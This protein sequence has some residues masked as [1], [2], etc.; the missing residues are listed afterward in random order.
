MQEQAKV[1]PTPPSFSRRMAAN[2]AAQ[3][4]AHKGHTRNVS[5]TLDESSDDDGPKLYRIPQRQPDS[6]TSAVTSTATPHSAPAS[7]ARRSAPLPLNL[8][9][10][11]PRAFSSSIS[12][13]IRGPLTAPASRLSTSASARGLSITPTLAKG[14]R[15]AGGS[16]WSAN[17]T[18]TSGW[19]SPA[20]NSARSVGS[21]ARQ[22]GLTVAVLMDSKE[23]LLGDVPLTPGLSTGNPLK[24]GG[25][26]GSAPFNGAAIPEEKEGALSPGQT[27]AKHDGELIT[28]RRA[29]LTA[30]VILCRYYHTPGLTCTSRPCR[31]V[32][33]LETIK[34]PKPVDSYEMMS[35]N[36]ADPTVGTFAQA[37]MS[38]QA[39]ILKVD[40]LVSNGAAPGETVVLSNGDGHEVVGT[41]YLMS[42]GGKGPAGKSRAKFKSESRTFVPPATLL[43]IAVPCKD[44]A[45]GT[46]P[47]GD[48]CSFIQ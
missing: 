16:I 19:I 9:N 26:L 45:A 23:M 25:L 10:K 24:S 6:A 38:A 1:L 13:L 43:T 7:T 32:H 46:C 21:T 11:P 40:E 28:T 44:Y 48:Y 15:G 14:P 42:G 12:P 35:P 18:N 8:P 34:S 20:L 22:R 4:L 29:E 36:E 39:K 27:A 5:F 41:V 31:F 37:Q 30:V 2:P 47:Y 17:P 33:N 3:G